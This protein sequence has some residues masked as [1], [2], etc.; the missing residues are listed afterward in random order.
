MKIA[1]DLGMQ[2][3]EVVYS[4]GSEFF[5]GI[6]DIKRQKKLPFDNNDCVVMYGSFGMARY[7]LKNHAWVPG[8]WFDTDSLACHTYYSHF[9]EYLLQEH[10]AMMPLSEIRRQKHW[11]FDTFALDGGLFIRPDSQLKRFAGQV[12]TE[13]GFDKF[14]SEAMV[15]GNPE[16]LAVVA[17]AR[18]VINEWRFVIADRKVISGSGYIRGGEVEINKDYP[19]EAAEYAEKIANSV[20]WQPHPIYCMDIC[21][22]THP[23]T[24]YRLL[25]IGSVNTCGLYDCDLQSIIEKAS[26]IA[27]RE[28]LELQN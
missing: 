13:D 28:W 17:K 8:V 4:E 5:K 1:R 24:E 22:I 14:W 12:I 7:L 9:G 23:V 3:M 19:K 21:E 18:N 20:D 10:Y 27:E 15:Y 25:E 26:E 16:T 6:L 11:I 2:A